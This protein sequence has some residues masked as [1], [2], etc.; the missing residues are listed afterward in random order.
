VASNCG[1]TM[2]VRFF[3]S[4]ISMAAFFVLSILIVTAL[5]LKTRA[6]WSPVERTF[7]LLTVLLCFPIWFHALRSRYVGWFTDEGEG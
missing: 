7:L 4:V 5:C 6:S 2:K 3:V 1:Q